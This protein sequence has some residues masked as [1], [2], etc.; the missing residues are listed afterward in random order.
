MPRLVERA[1]GGHFVRHF[2]RENATWQ[3]ESDGVRFLKQHDVTPGQ[4]F[5]T[6]LFMMLWVRG[7][8]WTGKRRPRLPVPTYQQPLSEEE[9][10]LEIRVKELYKTLFAKDFASAYEF[11]SRDM[12]GGLTSEEFVTRFRQRRELVIAEW[13][14]KELFVFPLVDQDG[15]SSTDRAAQVTM[16]LTVCDQAGIVTIYNDRN[17]YWVRVDGR[18]LWLWRSWESNSET[19]ET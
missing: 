18:W 14:I 6:D 3:I 16:N 10:D 1:D 4:M 9:R 11:L 13:R 7:M 12:P 8:V 5:Q 2:Y 17:D 19:E 15:L